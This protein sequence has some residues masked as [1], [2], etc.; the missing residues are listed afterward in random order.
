MECMHAFRL[1]DPNKKFNRFIEQQPDLNVSNIINRDSIQT[2]MKHHFNTY[3]LLLFLVNTSHAVTDEIVADVCQKEV[4]VLGELPSHGESL[5]F[6]AKAAVVKKLVNQCG[7]DQIYFE[8]PIYEFLAYGNAL[9]N[10]QATAHNL[11]DAMGGFWLTKELAEWRSWLYQQSLKGHI[12]LAGLDDQISASSRLTRIEL[13]KLYALYLPIDQ[14]KKC[15]E[16]LVRDLFWQYNDSYPYGAEANQELLRCAQAAKAAVEE[17]QNDRNTTLVKL[18][19][20][21][22]NLYLRTNGDA[23]A[24]S[25]DQKMYSNFVWHQQKPGK[26]GKHI[27][28]TATVHAAKEPISE[29]YK[30]LGFYLNQKLGDQLGVIGFT[31]YSGQSSMAG[32]KPQTLRAAP[33]DSLEASILNSKKDAIYLNNKTLKKHAMKPSRIHGRFSQQVWSDLYDG[34]VVFR[35]ELAPTFK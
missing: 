26:K 31:A 23:G 19:D 27:I 7:F 35:E 13:P 10:K 34:V 15:Q 32:N 20:N 6:Q 3:M 17:K 8:A 5:T 33:K 4:V 1:C 22:V 2:N 18:L 14:Q 16:T 21:L 12:H 28:W 29:K 30:P 25:R 11:D 24:V 9:Q